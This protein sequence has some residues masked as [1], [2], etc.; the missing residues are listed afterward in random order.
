METT[1]LAGTDFSG[2]PQLD[3]EAWRAFA[4]SSYGGDPKLNEPGAFSAWLR[5]FSAFGLPL[6][7]KKIQCAP[8]GRDSNSSIGRLERTHWDVRK[9][10]MEHYY[11]VFHIA[12]WSALIQNDGSVALA[13]GDVVL[14]DM[15][16]PWTWSYRS[17]EWLS[18]SLPR[19]SLISHLGFE[20]Q[21]GLSGSG[22][23]LAMK[24][25]YRLIQDA[26]DEAAAPSAP[27]SAYLQLAVYDLL[28]AVFAKS[29]LQAIS[30]TGRQFARV[31]TIIKDRFA[32]PDF[33]PREVAAEAGISPRSLQKLF[34]ARGS[35]C[36]HFLQSVRLNH[37][38]RLVERRSSLGTGQ[39]LSEIAYAC[40]FDDYGDFSRKFR[41]RFGCSP[42]A[43][44]EEGRGQ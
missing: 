23:T 36:R 12:G 8:A 10:D 22:G 37:A 2:A 5:P 20:P 30:H 29:N 41:C 3:C 33:G 14:L 4:R 18:L 32:D 43:Y 27:D 24:A 9:T 42:R 17:G 40:G 13:E 39:L 34:M 6:I 28:C 25:V 35:T 16:R 44:A 21:G 26:M 19:Q 11:A 1:M 38:A 15:S 7:A 31:C